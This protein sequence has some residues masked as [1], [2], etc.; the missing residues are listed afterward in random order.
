MHFV[1]NECFIRV[2]ETFGFNFTLQEILDTIA[3]EK[4]YNRLFITFFIRPNHHIKSVGLFIVFLYRKN[5]CYN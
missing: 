4:C 2:G 5:E 1:G 3:K